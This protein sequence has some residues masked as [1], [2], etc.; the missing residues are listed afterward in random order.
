MRAIETVLMARTVTIPQVNGVPLLT[1][2]DMMY[3]LSG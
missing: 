1:L 3:V 2:M